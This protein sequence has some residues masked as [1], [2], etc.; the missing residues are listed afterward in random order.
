[1]RRPA[2]SPR[3]NFQRRHCRC[4]ACTPTG[5]PPPPPIGGRRAAEA[6]RHGCLLRGVA[7]TEH[8]N[9]RARLT[10]LLSCP[11]AHAAASGGTDTVGWKMKGSDLLLLKVFLVRLSHHFHVQLRHPGHSQRTTLHVQ[12]MFL[13]DY[14]YKIIF[15]PITYLIYP[16]SIYHISSC[17]SSRVDMVFLLKNHFLLF[18]Q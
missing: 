12:T 16:S 14:F 9:R 18:P 1:V 17:L 15:Y 6:T 13:M 5:V 11:P 3:C 2:T 10:D 7:G 8:V 4:A